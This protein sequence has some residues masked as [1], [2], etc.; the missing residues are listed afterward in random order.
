MTFKKK[1]KSSFKLLK[2]RSQPDLSFEAELFEA[3][4]RLHD[5]LQPSKYKHVVFG[6]VFLKI[7]IRSL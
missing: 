6:L 5:K 1:Q 3:A 7:H 2:S 4:D